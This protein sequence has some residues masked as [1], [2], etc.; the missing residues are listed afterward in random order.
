MSSLIS[1]LDSYKEYIHHMAFLRAARNRVLN[2]IDT[3]T[4]MSEG[5]RKRIEVAVERAYRCHCRAGLRAVYNLKLL[6]E[7]RDVSVDV[8]AEACKK[9]NKFNRSTVKLSSTYETSMV[10]RRSDFDDSWSPKTID[11]R[12]LQTID[13]KFIDALEERTAKVVARLSNA[14]DTYSTV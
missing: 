4:V 8:L 5:T 1:R 11:P 3:D 14:P 9:L 7:R 10:D 12:T 2:G 6:C 13:P